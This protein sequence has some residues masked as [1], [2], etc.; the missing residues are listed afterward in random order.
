MAA[1]ENSPSDWLNT[2]LPLVIGTLLATIN[3]SSSNATRL[4]ADGASAFQAS[5]WAL[6]RAERILVL[7]NDA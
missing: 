3:A 5:E 2:P 6:N 4:R 1:S 7:A